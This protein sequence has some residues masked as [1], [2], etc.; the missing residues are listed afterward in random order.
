MEE[1]YERLLLF[2]PP[3][4]ELHKQSPLSLGTGDP[5]RVLIIAILSQ[6]TSDRNCQRAYESLVEHFPTWDSLVESSVQDIARAI[7]PGGLGQSKAP[8]IKEI[9][10][11]IYA[12]DGVSGLQKLHT[13]SREEAYEHLTSLPGVGPKTAGCVWAFGYGKPA[14]PVDTHVKRV[15]ERLGYFVDE[16]AIQMQEAL[17]LEVSP[18]IQKDLH[19]LLVNFGRSF[20]PKRNPR[21]R[22]CP[23]AEE[24]QFS[25]RGGKE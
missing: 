21:C 4:E 22:E 1:L 2:L 14:L 13:S 12:D 17:E 3:P 16:D 9:I 19:I 6:A 11:T 8:R 23:L 7:A 10:K 5:L 24:C 20:C 18:E 15:L 25:K